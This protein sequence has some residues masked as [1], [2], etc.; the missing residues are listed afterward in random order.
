MHF[1]NTNKN[2]KSKKS[3]KSHNKGNVSRNTRTNTN[4]S[5]NTNTNKDNT[6]LKEIKDLKLTIPNW[7]DLFNEHLSDDERMSQWIR[8]KIYGES[9][10]SKY[11]WAIPDKS[12]LDIIEHFQPLVELGAGQGYWARYR[13]YVY[14]VYMHI[15]YICILYIYIC[16]CVCV[17]TVIYIISTHT[18]TYI[19]ICN[20][21]Y[22]TLPTY[23]P[24]YLPT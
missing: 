9:M 4:T 19:C 10:V 13:L 1:Y 22:P 15:V 6:Y 16:V 11:A 12:S 23:L 17:V 8:L 21:K 3:N 7:N 5:T 18:Y 14:C 2:K 24:T 20:H